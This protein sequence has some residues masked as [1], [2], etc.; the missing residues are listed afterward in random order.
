VYERNVDGRML[1]RV[2]SQ[3]RNHLATVHNSVV[4]SSADRDSRAVLAPVAAAFV[5]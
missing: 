3:N 4:D 2:D 5:A 1:G